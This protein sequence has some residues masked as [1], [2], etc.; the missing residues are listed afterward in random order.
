MSALDACQT[1]VLNAD[2]RPLSYY[3]LSLW[4]W[5]DAVQAAFGDRV[6]VVATYDAVAR[7]PSVSVK[8]PSVVA[9]RTYLPLKR[10]PAFNRANLFLRDGYR[11]QYCGRRFPSEQLTFDHLLPRSKGGRAGWTNIVTACVGCN[12]RKGNRSPAES[13][14]Q[15]LS[16]PVAPSARRLHD[17]SRALV[18]QPVH[19][20]WRDYL[21]WNVELDP[22]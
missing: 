7:S 3:P 21:Y 6:D 2:Y 14:F 9:L 22:T 4:S 8:V 16:V 5:R 13:G 20:S 18:R 11:C 12:T 10:R 19:A 17:N 1:L 15:P